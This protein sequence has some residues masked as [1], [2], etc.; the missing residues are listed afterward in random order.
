M[1]AM[2]RMDIENKQKVLNSRRCCNKSKSQIE[3]F[4]FVFYIHTSH[5]FHTNQFKINFVTAKKAAAKM[6]SQFFSRVKWPR[7]NHKL[8][9]RRSKT[10][11]LW[12]SFDLKSIFMDKLDC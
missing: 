8:P 4:L 7:E 5:C 2:T 3:R 12:P 6:H 11:S 1:E 9:Q 10:K